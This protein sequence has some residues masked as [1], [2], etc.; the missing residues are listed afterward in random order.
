MLSSTAYSARNEYLIASA[1]G[2]EIDSITSAPQEPQD[3]QS[4]F[5]FDHDKEGQYLADV[6]ATLSP[7]G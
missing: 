2:H 5:T 6:F 7:R 1:L 3:F 4:P